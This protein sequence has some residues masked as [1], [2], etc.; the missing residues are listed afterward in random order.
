MPLKVKKSVQKHDELMFISK[1]E[2]DVLDWDLPIS[3]K[4][5]LNTLW[6]SFLNNN[7]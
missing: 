4:Y 6:I 7:N 5:N 1:E 3:W 2:C